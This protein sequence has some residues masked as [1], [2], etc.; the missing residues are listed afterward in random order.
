[1]DFITLKDVT[2]TYPTGITAVSSLDL[3]IRKGDFAFIIGASGSGKSIYTYDPGGK[4]SIAYDNLTKEVILSGERQKDR[5][6][7]SKA[8]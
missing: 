6:Q 5:I 1:M 3:T 7:S 2:K 8:R 4:T